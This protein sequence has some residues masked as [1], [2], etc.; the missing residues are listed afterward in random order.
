MKAGVIDELLSPSKGRSFGPDQCEEKQ[1]DFFCAAMDRTLAAELKAGVIERF[2]SLAGCVLSLKFA[3]DMLVRGFAPALA[4][5]EI[6]PTCPDATFH[7]WDSKSTGTDMVPPPCPQGCFT[8]R[9]DI[10][11]MGSP[12]FKAAYLWTEY[13]LN[14]FD[15]VTRTGI[16]WTR[17]GFRMPYWAEA[18]PLR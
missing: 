9:G 18:S 12:R 16:Y 10:W 2:Y 17:G 11:S 8:S 4:H 14:L 13:A 3:G 7:I 6:S 15:T 5:L 1:S